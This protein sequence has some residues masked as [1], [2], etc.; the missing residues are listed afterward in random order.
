MSFFGIHAINNTFDITFKYWF[1]SHQ[2][3]GEK[4]KLWWNIVSPC[5]GFSSI[6]LTVTVQLLL[7]LATIFFKPTQ[8]SQTKTLEQ[9]KIFTE[10]FRVSFNILNHYLDTD[11]LTYSAFSLKNCICIFKFNYFIY[12][13]C[14]RFYKMS[15]FDNR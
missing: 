1:V 8:I 14:W 12:F 13:F 4:I 3:T 10:F 11:I 5:E 7:F 6:R 2:Y 9:L 15:H